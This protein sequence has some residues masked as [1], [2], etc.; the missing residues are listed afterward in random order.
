MLG[1]VCTFVTEQ[2]SENKIVFILK[3]RKYKES[4]LSFLVNVFNSSGLLYVAM[5]SSK[6]IKKD[7]T[8]VVH[9]AVL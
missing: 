6:A 1:G 5:T 7:I 9:L 4:N 8:G 2:N 3:Q